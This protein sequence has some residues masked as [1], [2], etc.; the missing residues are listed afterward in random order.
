MVNLLITVTK[1]FFISIQ[2]T[3]PADEYESHIRESNS[4]SANTGARP[5]RKRLEASQ[6]VLFLVSRD[7]DP[8]VRIEGFNVVAEARIKMQNIGRNRDDGLKPG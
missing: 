8:T 4:L 2:A 6:H 3:L 1:A 7:I 5:C